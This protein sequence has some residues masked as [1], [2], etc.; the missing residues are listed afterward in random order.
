MGMP[1]APEHTC[2]QAA[3]AIGAEHM[4]WLV[5]LLAGSAVVL[6]SDAAHRHAPHGGM[7]AYLLRPEA[8]SLRVLRWLYT[9]AFALGASFLLASLLI[10]LLSLA[11]TAAWQPPAPLP[12]HIYLAAPAVDVGPSSAVYSSAAGTAATGGTTWQHVPGAHP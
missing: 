10:N 1:A 4:R 5:L 8:H 12:Q 7:T 9:A 11:V 2:A 3:A 6:A